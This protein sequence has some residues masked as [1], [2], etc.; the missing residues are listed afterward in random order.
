MDYLVR[1]KLVDTAR[2]RTP[3][4]GRALIEQQIIPT[5]EMCRKLAAEGRI[6]AGGPLSAAIALALVVRVDSAQELDE[7]LEGLPIWPWMETTIVPLTSFEGR[8]A[9]LAPRLQRI[10]AQLA[11]ARAASR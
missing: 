3:E 1:M 8:L 6:V 11:A 7:V 2:S 4:E 9:T 10:K 5:L